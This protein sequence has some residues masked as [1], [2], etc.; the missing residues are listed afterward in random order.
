MRM[1]TSSQLIGLWPI[2]AKQIN[3]FYDQKEHNIGKTL[4]SGWDGVGW[5]IKGGQAPKVKTL[6][7][8]NIIIV[9]AHMH[10]NIIEKVK[11]CN[12]FDGLVS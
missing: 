6:G 2:T 3:L 11:P 5:T 8:D 7:M 4:G 9:L 12:V 1:A 10:R